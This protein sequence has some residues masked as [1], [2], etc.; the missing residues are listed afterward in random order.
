LERVENVQDSLE[1]DHVDG[2][3]G[4]TV[5]VVANLQD[6]TA[7]TLEGFGAGRMFSKLRLENA[8][9]DLMPD[10]PWERPQVFA[11]RP[12]ETPV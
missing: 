2:A 7:E 4:V 3:I 1:A 12:D 11:A 8:L 10:F 9:A 6:P 5:K